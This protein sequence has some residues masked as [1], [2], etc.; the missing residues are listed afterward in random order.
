M[1]Q[2]PAQC[3]QNIVAKGSA[4]AGGCVVIMVKPAQSNSNVAKATAIA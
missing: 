1:L 2:Q 4:A 3:L